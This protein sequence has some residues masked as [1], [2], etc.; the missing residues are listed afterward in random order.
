MGNSESSLANFKKQPKSYLF[1]S[2]I[3]DEDKQFLCQGDFIFLIPVCCSHN[4]SRAIKLCWSTNFAYSTYA[5]VLRLFI[6]TPQANGTVKQVS[7][8]SCTEEIMISI[9]CI[10]MDKQCTMVQWATANNNLIKLLIQYLLYV[11]VLCDTY[12]RIVQQPRQ[13]QKA[14]STLCKNLPVEWTRLLGTR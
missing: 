14:L 12:C 1:A 3:E 11:E 4:L 2:S 10:Y 5:Y 6:K 8:Y 13:I 9:G 7:H